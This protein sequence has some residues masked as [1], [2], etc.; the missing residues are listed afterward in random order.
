MQPL[1]TEQLNERVNWPGQG[2]SRVPYRVYTDSGI[3]A[4]E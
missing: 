4:E 1:T 3:Y 2:V